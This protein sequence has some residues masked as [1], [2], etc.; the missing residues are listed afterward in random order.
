[1]NN[2]VA[3]KDKSNM[4]KSVSIPIKEIND[5][6]KHPFKVKDNEEMEELVNSVKKHGLI[7]PA[8]VRIAKDGKYEM[9]SGHRRKKAFELAGIKNMP[10]IIKN[11]TDDE[12]T[13]LMVDSNIQREELLP[14]E[15]ARAYKMKLDA[16][17]HQG[18]TTSRQVVEKLGSADLI[19]EEYGMSG[20][21]IQR[22]VRLTELI[23]E[24]LELVDEKRI[25][26]NPAVEL[27]Y[28]NED[29]QYIISD[30][31]EQYDATPSQAQAI[32]LKALSQEGNLTAEKIEDI[33]SE[34]KP[35]QK[36]KYKINYER[37]KNI[38][39][40]NVVTQKEIEDFFYL[41]VQEHNNRQKQKSLVR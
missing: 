27:S 14:S 2:T 7:H 1:M 6:P 15:K 22:Y 38:L 13:I 3:E 12:A 40:R 25:A 19:G 10:C 39:P 9:I 32:R 31:I 37:F 28:L 33:L 5:F 24:L 17:I 29:E 30:C 11:L 34:E 16:I 8:I 35:N 4:E 20:R 36:Q 41:C 18:K 23:P 21:Q 26:F